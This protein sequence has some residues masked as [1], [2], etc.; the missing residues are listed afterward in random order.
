QSG[1]SE[2]AK[3]DAESEA[4]AISLLRQRGLQ[5]HSVAAASVSAIAAPVLT[6]E[7]TAAPYVPRLPS[8]AP[9]ALTGGVAN[10][11]TGTGLLGRRKSQLAPLSSQTSVAGVSGRTVTLS[12]TAARSLGKAAS[13]P[14]GPA[15][16]AKAVSELGGVS[17]RDQMFFFR[18]LGSLVNSGMTLYTALENIAGRTPN[19]RLALAASQMAVQAHAGGR[20]SDVMAAYPHMFPSHV[21]GMVR[22]AELGGFMEIALSE[23][24]DGYQRSIALYRY[25][26]IPKLMAIQAVFVLALALPLF[27]SLFSGMNFQEVV[28]NYV[29]SELF[30]ALPIAGAAIAL[31]LYAGWL[32]GQPK[33]RRKR[34]EWSLKISAFGNLQRLTAI[35]AFLRMLKRLYQAGISPSYAWEAALNTTDNSA[36]RERLAQA[37]LIVE[38]G[39]PIPDAFQAT[40][41]FHSDVEQMIITGH[42]SGQVVEML[43]QAEGFYSSQADDALGKAR[44]A[45][46]RLGLNA[47]LILG[48][49]AVCW[50]MYSYFNGMFSWVDRY[51]GTG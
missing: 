13:K 1:K 49:A 9:A 46:F 11:A 35:T 41:L 21:T 7:A 19:R 16:G 47:M 32:S 23:I 31:A 30:L 27:P 8:N 38:Q 25:V 2:I 6:P 44:F 39:A 42:Q 3:I 50:M 4:E 22:A 37:Q 43:D 5:V 24:A 26:W 40:G 29:R 33:Y 28:G 12:G 15:P 10:P 14:Q 34:D 45:M 18:Q 48:G 51:F 20:I 36:I 17:T